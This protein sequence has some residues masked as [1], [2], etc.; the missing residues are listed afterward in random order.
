MQHNSVGTSRR[1]WV[2]SWVESFCQT[3]LSNTWFPVFSL[4]QL[5]LICAVKGW[6][7]S[8]YVSQALHQARDIHVKRLFHTH[9][10]AEGERT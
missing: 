9:H 3:S 5:F 8:A 4:P 10:L 2:S 1:R 7:I 6:D